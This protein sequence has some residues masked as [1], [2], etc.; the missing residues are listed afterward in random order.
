MA[1]WIGRILSLGIVGFYVWAVVAAGVVPGWWF[2]ATTALG[3]AMIWLDP[4]YFSA[5]SFLTTAPHSAPAGCGVR[6]LGW[7]LLLLPLVIAVALAIMSPA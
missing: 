3:L 7:F 2:I 6:I 4:D 1:K 5:F